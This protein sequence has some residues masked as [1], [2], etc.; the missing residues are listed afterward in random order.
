MTALAYIDVDPGP[1]SWQRR[2]VIRMIELRAEGHGFETAF[3][4][5]LAAHP[6]TARDDGGYTP[7]LFNSGGQETVVGAFRRYCRDAWDGVTGPPGS[8]NG[9]ALKHFTPGMLGET[10]YSTAAMHAPRSPRL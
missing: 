8:G 10:D 7:Q 2:A 9:P 4:A 5:A 6:P 3:T 1:A